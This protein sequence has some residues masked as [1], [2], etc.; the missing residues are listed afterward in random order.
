[1]ASLSSGIVSR[2]VAPDYTSCAEAAVLLGVSARTIA[3]MVERGELPAVRVGRT[4]RIPI[5]ALRRLP[6]VET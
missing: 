1:V 3:R 5:V 4:I 6:R 2:A